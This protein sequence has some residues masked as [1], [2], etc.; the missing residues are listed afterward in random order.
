MSESVSRSQ[1]PTEDTGPGAEPPPSL[2]AVRLGKW[3]GRVTALQAVSFHLE[4][5]IWGLLGP[6]GS[7]KSTLMGLAAGLLR[8][9]LGE[10]R[11]AGRAPFRDPSARA[12]VGLCPEQDRLP[13][14]LGALTWVEGLARL[15]GVRRA[16]A[17]D[18]AAETLRRL[19]LQDVMERPMGTYSRGMRQRAKLAQ[20]LVHRP[21]V[22]L[23]D[24]PLSG[25]DP[26][27]RATIL[28]EVSRVA[29]GGGLVLFSTHV[30]PEIEAVTDR[31]VVLVRGQLV[32]QGTV[33]ELRE[34]LEGHPRLVDVRSADPRTLAA[35]LLRVEGVQ[36]VELMDGGWVRSRTHRPD[37]LYGAITRLSL[38]GHRIQAIT[39]PD[40]SVEALFHLLV[41][42]A[43]RMAGTGADAAV[44]RAPQAVS[45]GRDV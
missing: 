40:D 29:E 23:L 9:S 21:D 12:R 11:V 35:A 2:R 19:R 24:E 33:A 37:E 20:A 34:A 45:G 44:G 7:G 30:L 8:P 39:S 27:S 41:E 32:G 22:L 16:L 13:P 5:G 43:S 25:T 31:V 28:E 26:L 42:R 6:N 1:R 4:P 15:S 17:R 38:E 14:E 3:Y 36:G 10:V 18:R